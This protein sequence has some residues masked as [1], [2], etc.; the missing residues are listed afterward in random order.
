M[1]RDVEIEFHGDAKDREIDSELGTQVRLCGTLALLMAEPD[2]FWDKGGTGT[3]QAKNETQ[4]KA[5][6]WTVFE[7][8]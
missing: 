3:A 6:Y 1:I 4:K 8:Q 7:G 5:R 2:R